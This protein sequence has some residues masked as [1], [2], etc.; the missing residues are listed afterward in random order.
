MSVNHKLA[1]IFFADI[2]GYTSLMQ[3]DEGNALI[4]LNRF[5]EIVEQEAVRYN[6]E[7]VQ[8]FGDGALLSFNSSSKAVACAIAMQNEFQ[9]EPQVPVRIGMHLGDVLFKNGNAFG[10]GVNVGSRIESLGVPGAVLVSKVIRDQIKNKGDYQLV[11]LGT[12]EFKNV[13]EPMEVYALSNPGLV[14]PSRSEMKGRL[15]KPSAGRAPM[16][17][18]WLILAILTISGIL[19]INLANRAQAHDLLPEEIREEKVAVA[20]FNNFTSDPNLDALGNMA[21]DWISAGLRALGV[22]TTSPEMMRRYKDRVGILPDNPDKEVSLMELTDAQYVVTG[23]YYFK[24]DSLQVNSRLESTKTGDNIYDFPTI[25]GLTSQ[26]EQLI[27]E[28]R[29]QLKGYWTLKES[30]KISTISPPK[31]EAY[32]EFLKC[33]LFDNK[34]LSQVLSI[35][36]SF[37]LARIRLAQMAM[38]HQNDSIYNAM[39]DYLRKHWNRYTEFEQNFLNYVENQSNGDYQVALFAMKKNHQLDPKDLN[40][41]HHVAYG[42]LL[43]NK[44][45]RTIECLKPI[46]DQYDIFKDQIQGQTVSAYLFALNRTGRHAEVIE[47]SRLNPGWS[48]HHHV[49]RALMLVGDFT[50][51]RRHLE[52]LIPSDYLRF[53]HMFNEIFGPESVNIFAPY[54]R[55]NLDYF[56]DPNPSRNYYVWTIVQLYNRDSKAFAY[57]LLKEW[58][59]AEKILLELRKIDWVANAKGVTVDSYLPITNWHMNTWRE[60]LWGSTY[61]RQGKTDLAHAQIA[62]LES[63]RASFPGTLNRFQKGITPYWQG[64]I[65]AILGEKEESVA[66]L[67]QSMKEGRSSMDHGNLIYAWDL[68]SLKGFEPYDELVRPR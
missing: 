34:C 48:T 26:E 36:S 54:L 47:F 45:S 43:L 21:S 37:I 59:K 5:K 41:L 24:G 20:V 40:T 16:K 66:Q 35:D 62:K 55:A 2:A 14:V 1:V 64:R 22:K 50:E 10:N 65:H 38:F 25:W 11:T 28:I 60:G 63:F 8:Y 52:S 3:A 67:A 9:R 51:V 19:W 42:Y 57:Y 32:Q 7:M 33:G 46:F 58:Q 29:E 53:T 18:I 13:E 56:A 4:I 68:A 44:P 6:G 15:K 61:A 49:I 17:L 30:D 31:F 12:F 23:S 27:T 39:G